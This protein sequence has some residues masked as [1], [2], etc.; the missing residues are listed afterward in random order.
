MTEP[1]SPRGRT[2]SLP[3]SDLIE[4]LPKL[5]RVAV[6]A[7]CACARQLVLAVATAQQADTEHARSPGGKQV[8]DGVTDDV[9]VR[10]RRTKSLG[11]GQ[12]EIRLGLRPLDVAALDDDRFVPDAE[13]L[14]G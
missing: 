2:G 11:A 8:P 10:G 14:E 7:E 9:A 1:P 12:E 3:Y 4:R 5:G 13:R 6:D